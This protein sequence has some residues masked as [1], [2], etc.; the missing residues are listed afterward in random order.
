GGA[1]KMVEPPEMVGAHI[2]AAPLGAVHLA[3][4]ARQLREAIPVVAVA[5]HVARV[6]PIIIAHTVGRAM[7]VAALR[8]PRGDPIVACEAIPEVALRRVAA[9][10]PA[11]DR[12][13]A[14]SKVLQHTLDA[15]LVI[16][17]H[18]HKSAGAAIGLRHRRRV[19]PKR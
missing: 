3:S 12:L 15:A 5:G 6:A 9:E 1:R 14:M 2:A 7:D 8:L 19:T 11:H 18:D 10:D 4:V 13:E 17:A 16:K